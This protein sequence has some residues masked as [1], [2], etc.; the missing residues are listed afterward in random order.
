MRHHIAWPAIPADYP[1]WI[2]VGGGDEEILKPPFISTK[3]KEPFVKVLAIMLDADDAAPASR[4][5]RIRS[6]CLSM[7]PAMPDKLPDTGLIVENDEHRRVGVWIMPDNRSG[8]CLEVFLRNLVPGD[9][10]AV[11][12]HAVNSTA[13]AQ[14]IGAPVKKCHLSKAHRYT[15]LSWQDE[16]T[17]RPG[18]ALTKRLLDPHADYAAGFVKWFR[19]L[20][21]I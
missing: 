7:F 14:N 21:Q 8:G 5:G 12:D 9:S 17:Q 10:A 16:P 1:V 15:W 11:W 6:Q 13:T 19:D 18:E 4:Y 3:L 20:Y 2:T